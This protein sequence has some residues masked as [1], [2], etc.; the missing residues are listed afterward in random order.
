M[1]AVSKRGCLVIADP[2]V[3]VVVRRHHRLLA[4]GA[5]CLFA[6]A[7]VQVP[8]AY[9]AAPYSHDFIFS[10]GRYTAGFTDAVSCSIHYRRFKQ[11]SFSS[12][13]SEIYAPR[14][15]L[16]LS[17]QCKSIGRHL[18]FLPQS[19]S[20][21][22]SMLCHEAFLSDRPHIYLSFAG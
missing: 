13:V 3:R 8:Q 12:A 5:V 6:F 1:P 21:P 16:H 11:T 2:A 20:M 15:N 17:C 19:R 4:A 22:P 9:V 10:K 18:E 14:S 7:V